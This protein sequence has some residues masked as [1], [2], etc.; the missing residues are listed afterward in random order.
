MSLAFVGGRVYRSPSD[1]KPIENAVVSIDQGKIS[2]V[3]AQGKISLSDYSQRIDCS[4]FTITAGF[5]NSHVHLTGDPT[6]STSPEV[7]GE[8]LRKEFA[9]YGFTTIVDASSFPPYT[10]AARSIIESG[11]ALGTRILTA[12]APL[13]PPD[14]IPFYLDD[15]PEDVKKSLPQPKTAEEAQALVRW[16]VS[17]GADIIKLFTGSLVSRKEV[18][19][20]E[21]EVARA[22]VEEAHSLGR[23]VFCHPSNF[24]GIN[25]ALDSGADVLA[26]TESEGS[27]WNEELVG[28]MK[29][30]GTTLVPTLKLWLYE[31]AKVNS[32]KEWAEEFVGRCVAQLNSF[33]LAGGRVVFGTDAGYMTDFDPM[34]EYVLMEKAGLSARAI[35]ESLT[36]A[37]AALFR[38]SEMRGEVA[39]GMKADLVVLKEDPFEDGKVQNLANV[40]MTIRDGKVVYSSSS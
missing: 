8:R 16:N 18:K 29:S 25:V 20:M 10:T 2:K 19:P 22:A 4:G 23:L 5:Q 3:G 39:Q 14:G 38:E 17:M 12:C 11:K 28:R 15:L 31:A 37:P 40:V 24:E 13:Y 33:Y 27:T 21:L 30:Q 35:L 36:A 32:S 9:Q 6:T 7:I 26:H 34:E 1:D